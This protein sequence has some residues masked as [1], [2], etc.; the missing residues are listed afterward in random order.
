MRVG[1]HKCLS[2]A[3]SWEKDQVPIIEGPGCVL[4]LMYMGAE[5]F[6]WVLTLNP[7]ALS[8]LL[9]QPQPPITYIFVILFG[10]IGV[11]LLLASLA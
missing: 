3:F 2:A 9:Q 7:P 11:Y 4:V 10:A 6:H 8:K 1:D 5:K